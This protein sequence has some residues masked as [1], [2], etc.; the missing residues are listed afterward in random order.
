MKIGYQFSSVCHYWIMFTILSGSSTSS[1]EY[2]VRWVQCSWALSAWMEP[3]NTKER[4]KR[5]K[6]PT[7][8]DSHFFLAKRERKSPMCQSWQICCY[9]RRCSGG[10]PFALSEAIGEFSPQ[11]QSCRGSYQSWLFLALIYLCCCLVLS[12]AYIDVCIYYTTY[13]NFAWSFLHLAVSVHF[14]FMFVYSETLQDMALTSLIMVS[15]VSWVFFRAFVA[16]C[17]Y[18]FLKVNCFEVKKKLSWAT[19]FGNQ[20]VEL[21]DV[22][23]F[24][25]ASMKR[26]RL[27]LQITLLTHLRQHKNV[28]NFIWDRPYVSLHIGAVQ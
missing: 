17:S 10:V 5:T 19:Q 4:K 7:S 2:R 8:F 1:V 3:Q 21:Q 22:E 11:T 6:V 26:E 23:L 14:W 15:L 24:S 20:S 12:A 13:T 18:C 28:S 9:W 16:D 25:I 27:Q